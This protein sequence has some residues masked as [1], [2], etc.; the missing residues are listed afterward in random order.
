MSVF[1]PAAPDSSIDR[2]EARVWPGR[3]HP[4]G[5]HWDGAGVNFAL[6]SERA[7]AVEVCLFARSDDPFEGERI[8]L[9]RTGHIWHGYVPGLAPGQTYGYRV[10]GPYRPELGLRFNPAKLLIDPY[11]RALHGRLDYSGPIY[12]YDHGDGDDLRRCSRDDAPYVPRGVVVDPSFD[13][14]DDAPPQVPWGD[15]VIY[16]THV[17]GFSR[18][19]PDVLPEQRGT[20]LGLAH[21]AAIAYLRELGVTAV[22]LL[23]VHAWVDEA[24]VVARGLT[25]YWGYNSIAYF[26]PEARYAVDGSLGQQVTEFKTMVK[27]LHAA[28]IEVILDVVYNHTGEGNHL[29]PTLSLRGIDN[30]VYYRL[31]PD[32]P[33]LYVDVTGTGNTVNVQR[34]DTLR[35]VMD[36]LRYWVEEMHVDGFRFDLA[37]AL[38]REAV[39]VD[40]DGSFFD[41]VHQDPVLSG[42]K[43]I[44]EPWDVGV[45]G[46]HVGGF[47]IRWSE[48]NDKYRD[49]I[50]H[51][52]RGDDGWVADLGYRLT[53][54]S[55]LF[56]ANGRRPHASINFVTSHDGFT[57]SDLISYAHK[58]NWANGEENRDGIADNISS[59]YGDEGPTNDP[60][61][62]A[63]RRRQRR[64][65]LATLFLSQG[66]PMLLGGDEI[67]R[68]QRGN[69]N[70][71]CQDNDLSWYSWR[72][73]PSDE[74]FLAFVQRLVRI[75]REQPVLRRGN[76]LH[77]SRLREIGAKDVT[78]LRPDGGEMIA[79]DWFNPKLHALG[80]VLH[81]DALVERGPRG[82]PIVG[83]TLAILLNAGREAVHFD[84]STHAE[85]VPRR[86]ETLIDT[87]SPPD[88][89][90]CVHDALAPVVVPERTVL[91][92]REIVPA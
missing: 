27:A 38:A 68:T 57:L 76:F 48:W 81:G 28:G 67:G 91:L 77:G 12:G 63:V 65:F 85:H 89:G 52:W 36:S 32:Q 22:E 46:Y 44:A 30:P 1:S 31:M 56:K 37:P 5:A 11:A 88:N 33:R 39:D 60:E 83:E 53:G 40:R 74:E 86:W 59:N 87:M 15:T 8:T 23:P 18:L 19:F 34:P 3:D 80:L 90:G 84:L 14:G 17:K 49:G 72:L 13:W 71:Y 21:P 66:T 82:E 50:R 10:Y 45:N 2:R 54:S 69:N 20:F 78:W 73:A 25:N 61:I 47:P 35:L 7:S 58:H 75:R 4:L 51:F 9:E 41:A 43:L 55:D 70:A 16:E 26:A 42:V 6:F 24:K 79:A 29:G 92:L 64:N 62:L